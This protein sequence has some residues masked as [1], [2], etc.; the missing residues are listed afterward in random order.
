[1]NGRVCQNT[2]NDCQN[3]S[4][5]VNSIPSCS[6]WNGESILCIL[7]RLINRL[8]QY[9]LWAHWATWSSEESN[10]FEFHATLN[11]TQTINM[12]NF[13]SFLF[14]FRALVLYIL[15]ISCPFY[16]L[17]QPVTSMRN[18]INWTGH[19][20]GLSLSKDRCQQHNICSPFFA[21]FNELY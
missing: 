4:T 7:L 10:L 16:W 3:W 21:S 13:H 17:T 20:V 2:C 15:S 12:L 19:F 5:R 8:L 6:R 1:M 11:L 9:A 18:K 14:R